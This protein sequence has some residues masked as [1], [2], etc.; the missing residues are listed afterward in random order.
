MLYVEG[1][2][3][4]DID[5]KTIELIQ[6]KKYKTNN[7]YVFIEKSGNNNNFFKFISI[8]KNVPNSELRINGNINDF[9]WLDDNNIIYSI[10]R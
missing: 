8:N 3:D 5:D 6:N 7:F 10:S 1:Y 4:E 9:T 2:N